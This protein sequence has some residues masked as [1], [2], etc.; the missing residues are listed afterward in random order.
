MPS[1]RRVLAGSLG[2]VIPFAGCGSRTETT[3]TTEPLATG[4][5]TTVA[6]QREESTASP[7]STLGEE[8][9]ESTTQPP[10]SSTERSPD[11]L[12][13]ESTP[14]SNRT[15]FPAVRQ[16]TEGSVL[17]SQTV[18]LT[19]PEWPED[20]AESSL[21]DPTATFIENT[22]F[23][24]AFLLG[25]EVEVTEFGYHLQLNDIDIGTERVTVS[26]SEIQTGG[27]PNVVRSELVFVR[28]PLKDNPPERVTLK[29]ADSTTS[30]DD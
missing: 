4:D 7:S 18:L 6:S 2:L 11:S 29:D 22:D 10:P 20:A 26:L 14:V 8:P 16:Y 25:I 3:N 12:T 24:T 30:V 19:G 27:G 13:A 28:L 15:S 21:D 9:L 23:E 17:T 5:S 1:R